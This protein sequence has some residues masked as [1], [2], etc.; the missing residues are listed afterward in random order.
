V[1]AS[2][3]A[4]VAVGLGAKDVMN[5]DDSG[6]A[7]PTVSVLTSSSLTGL[8]MTQV[9]EIQSL[10]VDATQGTFTVS[11]NGQT[12]G[13]LAWN[14]SAAGLQN[15]LQ[16][17][18]GTPIKVGDVAVTRNDDVYVIRFQGNLSSTDVAQIVAASVDL[19]KQVEKSA[20]SPDALPSGATAVA[21]DP[22]LVDGAVTVTTRL[23]GLAQIPVRYSD[24][25]D[26]L[27]ANTINDVHVVTVN[28]TGGTYTL[29]LLSG[30]S[31]QFT[32]LP[33]PF[34]ASAEFVRQTIQNAA[35]PPSARGWTASTTTA[36]RRS[37]STPARTTTCST[38]RGRAPGASASPRAGR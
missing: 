1:G 25:P 17:L 20:G 38:S 23:Q 13:P 4:T 9:N 8:S 37:T 18:P 10:V 28:A 5:V 26:H 31:Q 33:I 6:H 34:D 16:T 21:G 14:I 36:S 7:G 2:G 27:T 29:T 35:A 30:T 11:F 12:S 32:T 19:K 22:Q 15:A 24:A 3:E